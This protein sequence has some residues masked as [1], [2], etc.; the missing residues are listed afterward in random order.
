MG[1]L[2]IAHVTLHADLLLLAVIEHHIS[3]SNEMLITLIVQLL[4]IQLTPSGT[5]ECLASITL[6]ALQDALDLS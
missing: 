3:H 2:I 5:I 1:L 4:S 6:F